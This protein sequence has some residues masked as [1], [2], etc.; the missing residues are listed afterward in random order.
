MAE[1]SSAG[2]TSQPGASKAAVRIR[3][4]LNWPPSPGAAA[5]NIKRSSISGGP[6]EV[7]GKSIQATTF[8]DETAEPGKTYYYVISV[9]SP[10]GESPNSSEQSVSAPSFNPGAGQ[11]AAESTNSD[12]AG[13]AKTTPARVVLRWPN[14]AGATG[15]NIKRALCPGGPYEIVGRDIQGTSFDDPSAEAGKTYFYVISVLS[16][17]GESSN[18]SEQRVTAP[19]AASPKSPSSTSPK[20]VDQT[21]SSDAQEDRESPDRGGPTPGGTVSPPLGVSPIQSRSPAG[22]TARPGNG[23]IALRWQPVPH[24]TG[25]RI[26]RARTPGGPYATIA[27]GVTSTMYTDTS[28]LGGATYYYLVTPLTGQGQGPDSP[29]VAAQPVPPPAAPSQLLTEAGKQRIVLTWLDVTD[30][31]HYNIKRAP[32][33]GGP[34]N[35]IA[36]GIPVPTYTDTAV[37]NGVTYYY[38]VSARSACGE[39]ADSA[40]VAAAPVFQDVSDTFDSATAPSPQGP[41]TP[42]RST[43]TTPLPAAALGANQ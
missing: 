40:E 29:E 13:P 35:I 4:A 7:I 39:G 20:P 26:K 31:A 24:V 11:K 33:S 21:Q 27:S 14:T 9:L 34:Y 43:P 19:I 17:A 37:L 23:Y 41:S 16:P 1:D 38:V 32:R 8:A 36:A 6:Y 28:V 5:Y 25:Y 30:A 42:V 3:V 10:A 12:T 22:L 18:S 15:F 2:A